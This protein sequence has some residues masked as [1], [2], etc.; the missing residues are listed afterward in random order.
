MKELIIAFINSRIE[1][2][3]HFSN[4]FG[5]CE[6][7][8]KGESV[9]PAFYDG[10]GELQ[11]VANFDFDKGTCFHLNNGSVTDEPNEELGFPLR[12]RNRTFPLRVVCVFPKDLLKND[13]AYIKDK[14]AE[15]VV[16]VIED[17]NAAELT[18]SLKGYRTVINVESY[19]TEISAIESEGE[20]KLDSFEL[21]ACMIEYTVTL[22][23]SKK[24]FELWDCGDTTI[25]NFNCATVIDNENPDSPILIKPGQEYECV[26]CEDAPLGYNFPLTGETDTSVQGSDGWVEANV[27]SALRPTTENVRINTIRDFTTLNG[28][29]KWGNTNRFTDTLG[30]Q[31]YADNIVQVHDITMEIYRV[32]QAVDD[33]DQAVID[34]LGTDYGGNNTIMSNGFMLNRA[35]LDIIGDDSLGQT[36]NYA[37]ISIT[38]NL[39]TS[40]GFTATQTW[41]YSAT[42]LISPLN[43]GLARN[44]IFGRPIQNLN[45]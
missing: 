13:N 23:A 38:S 28:T 15:N 14:I 36:M 20:I 33:W 6:I 40:T 31:T 18:S 4:V 39:H 32:V 41:L 35:V 19:T 10:A 16:G 25:P 29:N 7:I 9:F 1:T 8:T 42:G 30:G 24:C 2:L 37:P 45:P 3:N 5:L 27:L 26:E 34:S 11:D 21:G 12:F 17:P 44:Y 43:K 22:T